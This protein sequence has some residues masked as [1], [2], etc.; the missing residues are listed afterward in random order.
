MDPPFPGHWDDTI[1]S[2]KRDPCFVIRPPE[3]RDDSQGLHG[4]PRFPEPLSARSIGKV[5]M[6]STTRFPFFLCNV[7]GAPPMT[8]PPTITGVVD[9]LLS[10]TP[11]VTVG[12]GM[13][14]GTSTLMEVS[15][16][17]V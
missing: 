15:F 10:D 8:N 3:F 6:T 9:G 5:S 17:T 7:T 11:F 2:S 4:F 12:W 13:G 14:G 1:V 16:T